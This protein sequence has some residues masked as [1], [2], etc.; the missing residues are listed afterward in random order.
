MEDRV[1]KLQR[2]EMKIH[3]RVESESFIIKTHLGYYLGQ[4]V[5]TADG[6]IMCHTK[7]GN[8][9][10]AWRQAPTEGAMDR[11]KS[12]LLTLN[13]EYFAY[14]VYDSLGFVSSGTYAMKAGKRF[15][16][17]ILPA[18]QGHIE[19]EFRRRNIDVYYE[20]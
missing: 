10:Y 6:V 18:L 9:C 4:V 5:L 15:A 7:Y 1:Y 13:M 2:E 14:V 8:F 19:D 17:K 3:D 20:R 11:F 12:F 16:K